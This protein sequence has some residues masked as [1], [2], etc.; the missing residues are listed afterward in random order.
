MCTGGYGHDYGNDSL[1]KK[2]RP[3]LFEYPTTNGVH[4]T[5]DGIKIAV[6]IGADTAD[7]E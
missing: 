1:L 4:C 6:Q 2:H 3:D 5:G 7:M